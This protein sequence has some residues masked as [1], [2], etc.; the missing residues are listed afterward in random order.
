M[1]SAPRRRLLVIALVLAIVVPSD[2]LSIKG[3]FNKPAPIRLL[4]N[5]A[6]V[7]SCITAATQEDRV[8]C[9]KIYAGWCK[10]C[11]KAAPKYQSLANRHRDIEFN[12]LL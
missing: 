2:G 4:E 7:S 1:Q 10:A 5:E 3:L 8:A 12:Q 9:I 6:A 11:K